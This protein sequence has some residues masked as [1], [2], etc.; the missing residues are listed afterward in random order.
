NNFADRERIA[1]FPGHDAAA[2]LDVLDL[3]GT[4]TACLVWSTPLQGRPPKVRYVDLLKSTKPH[5]LTR[6]VNNL[7]L[8]TRIAYTTSTQFYLEDQRNGVGWAT[9]LPFPVH[10]C[11]RV[12]HY[13]HISKHRFVSTYRYRHGFYDP[14]EREFRG[15]GYAEQRDAESVGAEIGRG[16]F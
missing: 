3:L 6:V 4:G 8:E 13:D 2:S 9:R 10:V 11:E 12:E 14:E 7:G 16:L 5:L 15:F 1:V